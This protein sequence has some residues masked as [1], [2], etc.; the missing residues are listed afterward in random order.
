MEVVWF[1]RS[2]QAAEDQEALLGFSVPLE[3][4]ESHPVSVMLLAQVMTFFGVSPG[5]FGRAVSG[6]LF[7]TNHGIF[8]GLSPSHPAARGF[9]L[10]CPAASSSLLF[11]N[12][13][14]L[15]QDSLNERVSLSIILTYDLLFV[16][17]PGP[18]M[19]S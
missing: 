8:F 10:R 15:F 5:S 17:V 18:I 2:G 3:L 4:S 9:R 16:S 7:C 1:A 11:P 14:G 6:G 19:F 12:P 13:S